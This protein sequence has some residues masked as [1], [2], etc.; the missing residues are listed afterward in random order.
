MAQPTPY[1]RS[2]SFTNAQEDDPDKPLPGTRLDIELDNISES[3]KALTAVVNASQTVIDNMDSVVTV[4]E[5]IDNVVFAAQN[6]A[7]YREANENFDDIQTANSLFLGAASIDP[8][9]GHNG[10]PLTL[11]A[12][13]YNTVTNKVMYWTGA[14]WTE[15]A[16]QETFDAALRA[17]NWT[18]N[19]V[20]SARA[21]YDAKMLTAS[22]GGLPENSSFIAANLFAVDPVYGPY[23]R[24][25]LTSIN[26][27]STYARPVFTMKPDSVFRIRVKARFAQPTAASWR[28]VFLAA[29]GAAQVR[30]IPM[31]G[32]VA[33][34][35]RDYEAI[36]GKTAGG[37][38][39]HVHP[40]AADWDRPYFRGGIAS[41]ELIAGGNYDVF[42][43]DV[44]DVTLLDLATRA[45]QAANA[46]AAA[47]VRFDMAQALTDP[48]KAQARSNMGLG[49]VATDNV[50][51]VE[52]GGTGA[53]SVAG[54]RATLGVDR[55]QV[56]PGET[57]V[58]SNDAARYLYLLGSGNWGVV[59]MNA[60]AVSNG[61]TGGTTEQGA[62]N[63]LNVPLW[64]QGGNFMTIASGATGTFT[65]PGGGTWAWFCISDT[66]NTI[67]GA[68]SGVNAGGYTIDV[69]ASNRFLRG[70]AWRVAS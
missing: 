38:V 2:F 31:T 67:W 32:I 4:A 58:T 68:H 3:S 41:V 39:T 52:R 45:A 62:R 26:P 16:V 35:V 20:I 51:P 65:L 46:A 42:V 64:P 27:F 23:V 47:S 56:S 40:T 37:I 53:T 60:L 9:T 19:K 33:G 11:G 15:G 21:V 28:P 1:E 14:L 70:F 12:T 69:G 18:P 17:L 24:R 10:V 13:Y 34:E 25:D 6:I 66:S 22:A 55:F 29:D 7:T 54:A 43:L 5:N 48:Q 59:N 30:S 36:I 61:G 44:E 63:G 49:S 57:R 8:T 50:V